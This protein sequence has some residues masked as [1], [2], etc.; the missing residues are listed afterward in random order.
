MGWRESSLGPGAL[1]GAVKKLGWMLRDF[2][3]GILGRV[4][5]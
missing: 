5:E 3:R 4:D 1:I 2:W